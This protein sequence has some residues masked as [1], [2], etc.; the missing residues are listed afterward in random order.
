MEEHLGFLCDTGKLITVIDDEEVVLTLLMLSPTI[1]GAEY[2][3]YTGEKIGEECKLVILNVDELYSIR[4]YPRI[5]YNI[6]K[7]QLDGLEYFILEQFNGTTGSGSFYPCSS[8]KECKK[9]IKL[10]EEEE[11]D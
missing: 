9:L 1:V 6:Y 11:E 7:L 8:Y 2:V 3:R 10:L 4:F 5:Y